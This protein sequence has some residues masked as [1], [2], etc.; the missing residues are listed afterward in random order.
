MEA[1][2]HFRY[3]DPISPPEILVNNGDFQ[4]APDILQEAWKSCNSG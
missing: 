1:D 2:V 4:E 3:G